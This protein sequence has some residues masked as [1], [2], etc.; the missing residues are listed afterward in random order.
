MPYGAPVAV[1]SARLDLTKYALKNLERFAGVGVAGDGNPNNFLSAYLDSLLTDLADRAGPPFNRDVYRSL[2]DGATW[3]VFHTVGVNSMPNA[4]TYQWNALGSDLQIILAH[5]TTSGNSGIDVYDGAVWNALVLNTGVVS[6]NAVQTADRNKFGMNAD[7]TTGDRT[8]IAVGNGGAIWRGTNF[9]FTWS[10]RASGTATS[11]TSVVSNGN[12]V[13]IAVGLNIL[14][15]STDDGLT[16]TAVVPTVFP[17][18]GIF[19]SL[20]FG[21]GRFAGIRNN[22]GTLEVLSSVDGLSWEVNFSQANRGAFCIESDQNGI[23][24][25]GA[26]RA[27]VIMT[28]DY[29]SF[30]QLLLGNNPVLNNINI[31]SNIRIRT[32]AFDGSYQSNILSSN[33]WLLSATDQAAVAANPLL[34]AQNLIN[35]NA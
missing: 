6:V 28:R 33:R 26:D 7:G 29:N 30:S 20:T 22:G 5:G 34:G 21:M 25:V 14:C 32:L 11:L 15:R 10:A 4:L 19:N 27:S 13:W 12:G 8:I 3:A 35:D 1:P 16:W 31:A 24:M 9:G 18:Q 17:S 23:V 2:D